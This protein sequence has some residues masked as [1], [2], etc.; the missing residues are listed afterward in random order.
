MYALPAALSLHR[1]TDT[2]KH[3][4]FGHSPLHTGG[5]QLIFALFPITSQNFKIFDLSITCTKPLSITRRK[6]Y[7][8]LWTYLN[9]IL[10]NVTKQNKKQP[11]FE[12]ERYPERKGFAESH[13]NQRKDRSWDM[14]SKPPAGLEGEDKHV[15]HPG[16]DRS[17]YISLGGKRCKLF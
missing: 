2:Q 1:H 9:L 3:K 16:V 7:S 12:T 4:T 15:C 10:F 6:C 8:Q 11:T 5:T 17:F 14:Q 13:A